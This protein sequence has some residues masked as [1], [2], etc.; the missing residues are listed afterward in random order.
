MPGHCF[1]PV[2]A[3]LVSPARLKGNRNNCYAGYILNWLNLRI[4]HLSTVEPATLW[5]PPYYG[6]QNGNTFLY[7][8]PSLMR[9]RTNIA[10]ISSDYF[11]S[12][13]LPQLLRGENDSKQSD[14]FQATTNTADGHILKSLTVDVF[15]NFTPLIRPLIWNR[16]IKM[17][18]SCQFH[19]PSKLSLLFFLFLDYSTWV[20]MWCMVHLSFEILPCPTGYRDRSR[21]GACPL[22]LIF[23]PN[24]GP[25]GDRSPP[26]P[27]PPYQRVRTLR[28]PQP[29]STLFPLRWPWLP[30][31]VKFWN[32]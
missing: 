16:K 24:C 15:Y 27:P 30:P 10:W 23:G 1:A 32:Y 14:E 31:I 17:P 7:K 11:E 19:W 4:P 26:P 22:P 12:L 6:H 21:G 2:L 3:R 20:Q 9:S 8:N 28:S 25:K 18:V 13:L 29:Q 5:P